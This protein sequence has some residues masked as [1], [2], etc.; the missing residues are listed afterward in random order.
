MP[1]FRSGGK[2]WFWREINQRWLAFNAILNKHR[3][4]RQFLFPTGENIWSADL[5]S[6][7]M[8]ILP[9]TRRAG[10]GRSDGSIA[11]ADGSVV[12][13]NP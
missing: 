8:F 13:S 10:D 4:C 5:R 1:F 7:A 12:K 11:T 6:D 9:E 3:R 2:P